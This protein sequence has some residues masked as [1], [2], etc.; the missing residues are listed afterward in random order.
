MYDFI[1]NGKRYAGTCYDEHDKPV[2]KRSEAEAVEAA[3]RKKIAAEAM[4][5]TPLTY[6]VFRMFK[7]WIEQKAQHHRSFQSNIKFY[8]RE[9]TEVLGSQTEAAKLTLDDVERFIAH[10]RQQPVRKGKALR[11]DSTTG[12]YLA[13][14]RAAINWAVKRGKMPALHVRQ[15]AAPKEMPNPVTIDQVKAILTHAPA[16]LKLAIQLSV[17]TGMRLNETLTL[18]WDQI[19]LDAGTILLK[20]QTTKSKVGQIVYINEA[21]TEVLKEAPHV[22]PEVI[23]FTKRGKDAEPKPIKSLKRSWQTAQKAAGVSPPHRFH[24]LRATFCTAVLAANNNPM[25]LRLAARHASL[26]TTMRYAQ[27]SDE[28]VRAAFKATEGW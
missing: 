16:H 3:L 28:S 26:S 22:L 2:R 24:D 8:V 21:L 12:R 25:T 7:D 15:L 6:P 10:S 14:L 27:V 11:S 17:H 18:T 20:S 1:V 5:S 13:A 23:T 9:L 4:A 19:D